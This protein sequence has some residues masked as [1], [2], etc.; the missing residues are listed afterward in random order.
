MPK[1]DR[2]KRTF[3]RLETPS[4]ADAS[5]SERYDLQE[6]ICNSPESFF[7]EVGQTLFL[8]AKEV[9]PSSDFWRN[10]LSQPDQVKPVKRDSCLSFL[11]TTAADLDFFRAAARDRLAGVSWTESGEET[12]PNTEL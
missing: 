12:E 11:L 6:Y 1:I 5:I 4:L 3:C 8:I 2:K 9:V 7:E 10:G